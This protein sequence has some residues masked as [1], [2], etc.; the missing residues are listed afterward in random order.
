MG[1]LDRDTAVVGDGG[2]YTATLSDDWEI[3]GPNGGYIG[4]ILLRAAGAS[5]DL[6]V[7]ASLAVHYLARAGFDEVQ[8]QVRTLRRTRRAEAVAVSMTQ[9]DRAIAEGLA[10]FIGSDLPG[11]EHDETA[12][13]E[14]AGPEGLPTM[15]ERQRAAGIES[16]FRF[17]DNLENR[18]LRWLDDWPPPGPMPPV[19]ESWFRFRPTATFDDPLV[20]AARVV[21]VLDTMGW[22]AATNVHAWQWSPEGPPSWVA[23]SLDLY[24][25]FHQAVPDSEHLF[26]R[27]EAPLAAGA[28][29]TTE[30]RAW[31][32]DGRLLASG[33]SQLLSTP[34][35]PA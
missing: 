16:P 31:S 12:M 15:T 7:P 18:P 19:S 9:G 2:H 4:A 3:W 27:M 8:L 5:T 25:R 22:P 23:P 24:V 21:V 1:D 33:S 13:P 17:W 10:W 32:Q 11:L 29:I 34:V 14:V 30:G 35:P 6:P 26:V 20:D 28:L